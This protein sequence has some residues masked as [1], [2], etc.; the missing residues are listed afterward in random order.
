MSSC[1]NLTERWEHVLSNGIASIDGLD[2]AELLRVFDRN[3]FII[4]SRFF[5]NNK[6]RNNIRKMQEV[7]NS[8]AHITPNIISKEKVIADVDTIVAVMQA[9]DASM[10][11]TRDMETF[12]SCHTCKWCNLS[13]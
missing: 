12:I 1:S 5:V 7:R 3:W 8:W 10:K 9:F 6:E 2:L 13:I 11:E 4:T